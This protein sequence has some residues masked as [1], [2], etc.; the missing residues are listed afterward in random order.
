MEEQT[1]SADVQEEEPWDEDEELRKVSQTLKQSQPA[2]R[3]PPTPLSPQANAKKPTVMRLLRFG[4]PELPLVITGAPSFP[5][6]PVCVGARMM[7]LSSSP[8]LTPP[9]PPSCPP[10]PPSST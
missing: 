1:R 5:S 3:A 2:S 7:R 8:H 6:P 4:K 9:Q 10:S